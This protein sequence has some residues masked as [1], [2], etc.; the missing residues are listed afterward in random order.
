M[1]LKEAEVTDD[2]TDDATDDNWSISDL[3]GRFGLPT[4]VLRHWESIGLIEP[5]RDASGYRRYGHDDLVRVA[6]IQRNKVAGMTLEQIRVL[7]D[8]GAWDRH[9]VLEAHLRDIDERMLALERSREM[10]EHALRCRSHDITSCPRFVA[11]VADL[12]EG[13]THPEL[14]RA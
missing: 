2:V 11:A 1:H 6:I 7:L 3:A 5:R 14:S 12:V 4:H 13:H 9:Q 10:T 8:A